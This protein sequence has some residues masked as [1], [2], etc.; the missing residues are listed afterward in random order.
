MLVPDLVTPRRV[1]R[2][3][4]TRWGS[5]LA[6]GSGGAAVAAMVP[7]PA[8]VYVIGAA[9]GV[10]WA[11][12]LRPSAGM[13]VQMAAPP[14]S[15][16]AVAMTG[17]ARCLSTDELMSRARHEAGHAVLAF[18]HGIALADGFVSSAS[19]AVVGGRIRYAPWLRVQTWQ[20]EWVRIQLAWGGEAVQRL[21]GHRLTSPST[22]DAQAAH[23]SAAHLFQIHAEL[24]FA[25]TS[26]HELSALALDAAVTVVRDQPAAVRAAARVLVE[27]VDQ[28]VAGHL[29]EAAMRQAWIPV[30]VGKLDDVRG[31]RC[32]EQ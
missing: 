21:D 3:A 15:G 13:T 14:P 30:L 28:S 7:P 27:H 1:A 9:V 11:L 12:L 6:C 23:R 18:H 31:E 29:I 4:L 32:T 19:S 5:V 22:Y 25:Y 20:D 24:G 16:A 8:T 10:M 26:A 2:A 17:T